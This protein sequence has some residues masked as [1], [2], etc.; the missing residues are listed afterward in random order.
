MYKYLIAGG[1][2]FTIGDTWVKFLADHLK[3]DNPNLVVINTA[4]HSQGQEMI[5]KKVSLAVLDA[6]DN[7]VRPDEILCVVMWSGNERKAWYVS[8]PL[9]ID[10]ILGY[11]PQFVGGMSD[12]FL[13]LYNKTSD[14]I[15]YFKT[16]NG[17]RFSYDKN[18]GWYFTVNGS[19]TRAQFIQNHYLFDRHINGFGK[20]HISLEN[21]IWLQ[22]FCKANK[23]ALVQ[24]FFMD[25]V[26]NKIVEHKD[27]EILSY[28]YNELDYENI[29]PY[30]I[31]DY[32]HPFI[33][34]P[35]DNALYVGHDARKQANG[36]S[37]VFHQDGFHPG[38]KG[39][40]IWWTNVLYPFLLQRALLN[41]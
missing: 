16:N 32:L 36:D 12:L 11:M 40:E 8:S 20:L 26:I 23:V 15:G 39:Y 3:K 13:D 28:L 5:Q 17:S 41:D 18:G 24:Q 21:I 34:L 4:Y 10:E 30:G 14:N 27:H 25:N 33:G 22:S 9:I 35:R 37:E 19:E 2:S 29:I 7:G 38:I 1:C 31:F 6:F